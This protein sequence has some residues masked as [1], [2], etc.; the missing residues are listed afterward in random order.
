[1]KICTSYFYKLRQFK[2]YMIPISTAMWDPKWFHDFKN[3]DYV[4]K[5]KNGVYNG[6]RY[7]SFVPGLTC[8][9][10]CRGTEQCHENPQTCLFLQNY[11]KQLQ[12]LNFNLVIKELSD[13]A[14]HIKEHEG[15]REEPIIVL[16]V[17]EKPE[18]E[19]SERKMLQKWFLMHN[20]NIE[21]V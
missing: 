15:F 10:L 1:M 12:N 4:F 18:M 19:C 14:N 6:L 11:F 17:Y 9:N 7:E 2:P 8:E 3:Q 21:E 16:M 5:D 13:L 20:Y